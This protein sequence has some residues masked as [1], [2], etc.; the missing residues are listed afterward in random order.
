MFAAALLVLRS[1]PSSLT[2]D[3]VRPEDGDGAFELAPGGQLIIRVADRVLTRL[4]GVHVTGGE[5]AFEHAMRR[6]RGHATDEPFDYG[7]T[8]LFAA[9]GVGYLIA[10][11]VDDE[12]TFAAVMLDDDIFYLREDLVFA[13]ESRLRWE[14]GN[15]PGL[16]G[17]LPV[18]QF[19]GDGAVALRLAKP[20]VRVKL[21]PNGVV[22][23]D[24]SRLGGWIGR[25]IPRAVVPPVGSPLG[26][27]CVEC[28]GE[29][30]VLIDPVAR[31]ITPQCCVDGDHGVPVRGAGMLHR[32]GRR[33]LSP[34]RT[35]TAEVVARASDR[36]RPRRCSAI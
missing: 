36:G 2:E 1:S 10:V 29:G 5:L 14:N 9:T 16:R 22:F 4:D 24:A 27:I 19:R 21:A 20:L 18:V 31:A 26:E 33:R 11:P 32:R 15:V 35:R 7:G 25:V 3:P 17:K 23:V 34:S 12:R 28:S 8:P 13:F 30:I 6:S